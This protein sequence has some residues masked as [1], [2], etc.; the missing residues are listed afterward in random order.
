V[1][2]VDVELLKRLR[3]E[4]AGSFRSTGPGE[5]F[6]DLVLPP[7]VDVVGVQDPR[8]PSVSLGPVG[9]VL[10]GVGP[11]IALRNPAD[12]AVEADYRGEHVGFGQGGAVL[13]LQLGPLGVEQGQKI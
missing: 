11:S 12:G 5:R 9:R 13:G 1:A 2:G 6:R 7:R 10:G 4:D 8:L 3:A